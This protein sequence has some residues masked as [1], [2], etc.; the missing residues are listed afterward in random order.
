MSPSDAVPEYLLWAGGASSA[1]GPRLAP[2]SLQQ[3]FVSAAR[4][5]IAPA[6][7]RGTNRVRTLHWAKGKKSFEEMEDVRWI[8]NRKDKGDLIRK[9][10]FLMKNKHVVFVRVSFAADFF[11]IFRN[12]GSFS[13]FVGWRVDCDFPIWREIN[14][15]ISIY[16]W[17][18][19]AADLNAPPLIL[20]SALSWFF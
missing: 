1:A 14:Q 9:A 12:S 15:H 18:E 6:G 5:H 2:G 4:S 11:L 17:W 16:P 3:R 13:F 7:T 19:R 20:I 10:F 8:D